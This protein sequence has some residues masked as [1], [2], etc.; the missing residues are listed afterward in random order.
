MSLEERI[1]A[2]AVESENPVLAT[3]SYWGENAAGYLLG[4][5]KSY[6]C[7]QR[8][9]CKCSE[10]CGCPDSMPEF[11]GVFPKDKYVADTCVVQAARTLSAALGPHRVTLA[12]QAAE[13]Q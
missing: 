10:G 2:L 12:G 13:L 6:A 8:V 4:A 9:L 5:V 1:A 11:R 3:P 7:L